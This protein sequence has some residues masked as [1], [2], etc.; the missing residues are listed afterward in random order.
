MGAV[1]KP[2]LNAR[3]GHCG[4]Y[5]EIIV[6]GE[7][8][9]RLNTADYIRAGS[10][11]LSLN[12]ECNVCNGERRSLGLK[13]EDAMTFVMSGV[14]AWIAPSDFRAKYKEEAKWQ[15]IWR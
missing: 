10:L 15:V 1:P 14:R 2:G 9:E 7:E 4:E 13:G 6:Q 5:C 3:R 11:F 8:G 12:D